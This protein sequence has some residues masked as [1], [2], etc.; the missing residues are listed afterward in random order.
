[1]MQFQGLG[2]V[3]QRRELFPHLGCTYHSSTSV[4]TQIIPPW[5]RNLNLI[6]FHARDAESLTGNYPRIQGRLTRRQLPFL[7]N[8]TPLRSSKFSFEYLLL[9]PRSA[10]EAAP[11]LL[12]Q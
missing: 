7:R 5:L 11:L 10:L 4:T 12:T 8:L 1:M 6:L 3:N 9:L 2:T